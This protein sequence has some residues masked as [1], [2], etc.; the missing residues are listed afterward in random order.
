MFTTAARHQSFSLHAKAVRSAGGRYQWTTARDGRCSRAGYLQGQPRVIVATH[1]GL[2]VRGVHGGR[3]SRQ[4]AHC[5]RPLRRR[6]PAPRASRSGH[7]VPGPD[8]FAVFL[9]RGRMHTIGFDP[10]LR[11]A[12][13]PRRGQSSP[14]SVAGPW[15]SPTAARPSAAGTRSP[16]RSAAP[17]APAPSCGNTSAAQAI[18]ADN[19][20]TPLTIPDAFPPDHSGRGPDDH[21]MPSDADR[22]PPTVDP[23]N[24]FTRAVRR[25]TD[26][27]TRQCQPTV[28]SHEERSPPPS[29]H[30]SPAGTTPIS[31]QPV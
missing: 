21:R 31:R 20:S 6:G 4:R 17:D 11:D 18:T 16:G 2:R 9:D 22:F 27:S 19:R 25:R 26:V 3:R 8:H 24:V 15:R 13:G 29:L 7:R 1:P 14:F 28:E 12:I 10:H 5:R 23:N 30:Q